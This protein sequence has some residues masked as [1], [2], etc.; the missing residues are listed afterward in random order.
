MLMQAALVAL[1]ATTVGAVKPLSI[2]GTDFVDAD[3]NKF[4][5]VGVA[6]QPGGSSGYDPKSGKDPLSDADT[7]LRDAALLQV[8]GVNAI[9][10]YNLDPNLNHDEC[11]SIFNAAGMYMVLDVNSPLVGESI[12]SFEPWTSYYEAYS[13]RTFAIAEAF[14]NY[15]NTLLYFS[16]NEVINDIPSAQFVPPYL[17]AVTR[18]LKNYIKKNIKRQIPVGYSAA[19]V[20]DVLWDTWNYLQCSEPNDDGD[21]SRADVFALNSYSWCGPD[22]TYKS[23]SYDVLTD[24]FQDTSVPVFFSEYGCNTPMP[25]YWN[26]TQAIYGPDMTP[27]FSGGFVYEYTEEDN[28][29]GL[30]NISGDTLNIMGDYNRL[31]AQLAKIDWKSLQSQKASGKAPTP[32]KCTSSLIKEKGFDSNFTLPVPPPG[33]QKLIDNGISPKPSGSIVKISNYNVKMSVK[34]SEGNAVTGLKVVPLSD[35][36][37]NWSGKN[38]ADTGSNSTTI[39]STKPGTSDAPKS[40]DKDS[41]AAWAHPASWAL[42]LPL[43][44]MLFI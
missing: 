1:A 19:D 43:V 24:N 42:A 18:D 14:S 21:M 13:N 5:L 39:S 26:E 10:V 44:A 36:E 38:S 8:M 31:K 23:S 27:V 28:H 15:P 40:D 32:P 16:G 37:S 6:Y 12:T 7:C 34:D 9:R 4:Q 41:A 30:V 33:V 22:A 11:A 25:R 3:G 17:R 2:K 20:R 35:D 29:Y